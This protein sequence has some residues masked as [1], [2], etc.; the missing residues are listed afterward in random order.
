ME[1]Y[2]YINELHAVARRSGNSCWLYDKKLGWTK[3]HSCIVQ[4]YLNGYDPSEP[5][6]SPYRFGNPDIM[7]EITKLSEVK[8]IKRYFEPDYQYSVKEEDKE[9]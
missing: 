7:R 2:Y 8:A 1:A 6:G 4:D 9:P 5:V 3:V